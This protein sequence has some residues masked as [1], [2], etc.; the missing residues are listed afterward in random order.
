MARS[1]GMPRWSRWL[2]AAIPLSVIAI[3]AS[4]P[5]AAHAQANVFGT[6]TQ[7]GGLFN[8]NLNVQNIGT[9]TL[10]DINFLV[11]PGANSVTNTVPPAGFLINFDSGNGFVD[12]FSHVPAHQRYQPQRFHTGQYRARLSFHQ[13][14]S[15][16][17]ATVHGCE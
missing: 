11:A 1:A 4:Q 15:P 13:S 8:Y 6:F 3:I 10:A 16:C 9:T 12:F 5:T 14:G 2:P 7:G 17:G